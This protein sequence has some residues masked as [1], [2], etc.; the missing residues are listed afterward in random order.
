MLQ[1]TAQ[2]VVGLCSSIQQAPG[3]VLVCNEAHRFLAAAQLTEC[4]ISPT[5]I[6]LEHS[7]RNTAPAL[8]I[9]AL[10]ARSDG[11]DP[12]ILAMPADHVISDLAVFQK[13]VADGYEEATRGTIVTFGVAPEYPETGYGYIHYHPD[14]SGAL[15]PVRSFTE[16]PNHALAT[17][18][19]ESGNYLWN[20]G[21]FMLRASIWLK[22]VKRTRLD[23]HSACELA[24]Q[25]A[26]Y[27]LDF[28]RPD[29]EAFES[30]PSESV[31]YAVL[32]TLAS[33]PEW[34]VPMAVAPML[35]GWSDVGAWDA[36]WRVSDQD[37]NGNV[38]KGTA[39]VEHE[40]SNSLLMSTSRLVA[41]VGL[42]N[43]IVVETP[44]AILVVNKNHTQGVKPVVANLTH[45]RD[46]L[47]HQHRKVHRPWGWYDRL[48]QG[49]GFQVKRIVVNPGS[50][51]S[52]QMHKHRA[53]HWVVVEG[54]ADVT[55][56][57]D[58]F[59]L[60]ENESTYIKVGQVH[61]LSNPGARPLVIIEIQSGSYLGEDDIVRFEDAYGRMSP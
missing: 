46:S 48:D 33:H 51:L 14:F 17:Q 28:I 19:V 43:L 2:R 29:A 52:L 4:G 54:V 18:Y 12:V 55:R 20:S 41:G 24:M 38:L 58:S 59:Q 49:E 13:A 57:D 16:K 25:K 21:I 50:S 44:D 42:E 61:R 22:A 39:V 5:A 47:V 40:C 56:G 37:A 35:A 60:Q 1:Q 7:A 30:C 53:E 9:A 27:D 11:T 3:P 36:L 26:R 8:T 45:R 31:D 15:L 34:G 10:Q 32:E 23:I 6:I